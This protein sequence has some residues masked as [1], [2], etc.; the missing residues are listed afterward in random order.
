MTAPLFCVST[1]NAKLNLGIL[2][3]Y[4][5]ASFWILRKLSLQK[6]CKTLFIVYGS[7]LSLTDYIIMNKRNQYPG[8]DNA[9]ENGG[10]I[11]ENNTEQ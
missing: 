7:A 3:A 8:Y 5:L 11:S 1:T 6:V 9:L 2:R 4:L 10:E